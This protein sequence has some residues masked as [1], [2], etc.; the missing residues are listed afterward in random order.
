MPTA[1]AGQASVGGPTDRQRAG[2]A[3]GSAHEADLAAA[4]RRARLSSAFDDEAAIKFITY[5]P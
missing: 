1:L 5:L 3:D 2:R 4:R